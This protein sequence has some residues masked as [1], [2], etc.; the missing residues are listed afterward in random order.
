VIISSWTRRRLSCLKV[1]DVSE[2]HI[3]SIFTDEEQVKQESCMK[4][5]ANQSL[6][7]LLSNPED[8]GDIFLR[9]V[10]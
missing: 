6:F 8:G 5:A 4:Q 10:D 2:G 1:A 3:F 7:G 9:N